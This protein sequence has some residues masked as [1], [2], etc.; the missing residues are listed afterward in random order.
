MTILCDREIATLAQ[1]WQMIDPFINSLVREVDE[2]KVIS[3]GLSSFGY[4]IRLSDKEFKIFRHKPGHITDPK[5]FDNSQLELQDYGHSP[6]GEKYYVLP[7]HSYGLG[8]SLERIVMPNNVIATCLGKSTYARCGIQAN[9][10]PL[11]PGWSGH[12]TLE[13]SNNSDEDARIYANEGICQL[14]FFQGLAPDTTYA[15]RGGKYMNQPQTI[16]TAK[17]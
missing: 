4:D 5:R 14:L 11:E 13:I 6:N 17:V 1:K 9:V 3:Y 2:R 10:T 15:D 8:V 12:I 16:V 7:A